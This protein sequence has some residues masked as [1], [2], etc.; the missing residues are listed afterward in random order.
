VT[1]AAPEHGLVSDVPMVGRDVELGRLVERLTKA[2]AGRGGVVLIA[3]EPGIGKTRL[4]AELSERAIQHRALVLSG[5]CYEGE[6][7]PP[8][9]PFAEAVRAHVVTADPEELGVDLGPAAGPLAQLVPAIRDVVRDVDQPAPVEPNEERF[10]LLDAMARFL[11]AR[12]RR[13]PALLC[14]DDLHWA[15]KGTVALLRYLAGVSVQHRI[16]IVGA[17]RDVDLERGHPFAEVL[18]VLPRETD[19]EHVVLRG[20]DS[21]G[22]RRLLAA[23]G[24]QD[25]ARGVGAAWARE[26]DGNPFFICELLRHF[27]EEGKVYRGPD[28]QWAADRPLRELGVPRSVRD[29]IGRRLFQLSENAER[30]LGVACAFE[31]PFP[32][33]VVASAAG[34]DEADALDALDEALAA[35]ILAVTETR[36]AFTFAHALIR[37]TLYGELSPPR[38]ARLH[39]RVA[40][41]LEQFSG[42][43]PSPAR[44]GEIAFQYHRSAGLPGAERGVEFAL[45]AADQ[46]EV[47][48][49]HDSSARLLCMVLVLLPDEDARRPVLLGRLGMALIWAMSFDQAVEVA[50]EAGE[51]IARA[52]GGDAAAQYLSEAAYAANMAGSPAHAWP[53]ARQGLGYASPRRDVAWARLVSFDHMRREAEDARHPGI[54]IVTPE[55]REAAR[56]LRGAGLDPAGPGPM[57]A[58]LASR[59]DAYTSTNF[60][61]LF[62][63]AG[64]Y[65]DTLAS[66]QEETEISLARGQLN[67]A[68]R[69]KAAVAINEAALGR[70]DDAKRSLEES[71]ALTG[72]AGQPIWA[73]LL[74]QE[75]MAVALDEGLDELAANLAPLITSTSPS[76]MWAQGSIYAWGARAAARLGRADEAIRLL[77]RLVPWLEEAPAWAIA[78]AVMA[79][80]G[81]EV[82]WLLERTD[83]AEVVDRA[84]RQKVVAPDFRTPMVDGRLALARLSALQGRD[85]EALKWLTEAR[86]VLGEQGALSLLAISDFDEAIMYLRCGGP[87]A[88]DR[89][90]PLLDNAIRQFSSLGMSGWVRRAEETACSLSKPS[91]VP[92]GGLTERETVVLRLVA[93]GRTNKAIAAEL[94]L[95][96]KTVEHHVSNIF[97]KLGVGSR[98]AATSLAHRRG[99]I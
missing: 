47:A 41:T 38:Q 43:R 7:A 32:F 69:C 39:G 37:Y 12:S 56:I 77:D 8:Y 78:F 86:R 11:A 19:Y 42:P 45:I 30:L 27:V 35:Q 9:A 61:V 91:R 2:A 88:A 75:T 48:A 54:P 93:D 58:V 1:G 64:E 26:T 14:L 83:H 95:S 70:L 33:D 21:E 15:D 71:T 50:A 59:A 49:A 81:A 65:L 31:G 25:V 80:H 96:E 57:E 85:D 92:A 36:E 40:Q 82:L 23:M 34:L 98:A 20:L 46:A 13:A 66:L 89:A 29:V 99:I 3:G 76:L 62:Y 10:R 55:R 24:G 90:R 72:R 74:A 52:N 44:A 18:G 67:R 22:T 79:C 51:A 6:W 68:A 53:L 73:T 5:H 4:L 97:T 28:G 60:F 84:L 94:C 87:R 17:Y 63:W 16:L